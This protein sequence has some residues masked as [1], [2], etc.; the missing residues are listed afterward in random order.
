MNHKLMLKPMLIGAVI[1]AVASLL[2]FPVVALLPYLFLLVCP[3][4]MIFMMGGMNHGEA[5][6]GEGNTS[7]MVHSVEGHRDEP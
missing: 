2:G 7:D 5:H 6:R 1:L 4:M 3:L